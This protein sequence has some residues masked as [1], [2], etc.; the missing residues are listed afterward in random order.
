MMDVEPEPKRRYHTAYQSSAEFDRSLLRTIQEASPDG[1]LVVDGD[2]VIVSYNQ[3]FIETWQI[4]TDY[5]DANLDEN[6][7]IPEEKLMNAALAQLKDPEAFVRRV[8]ELYERPHEED[9]TEL[10]LRNGTVLERHSMGLHADD[11]HYF[12]RVWFFR[13]ITERKQGEKVL[14]DMAWYDPLTKELNRGHF[15][16]RAN[17]EIERAQRSHTPIGLLMLDLDHFKEVNDQYGHA[18]GDKVLEVACKRWRAALRSIDLLGR[19]GGEEFAIL[20]PDSDWK[21]TQSVA[22]RLR[23]VVADQPVCSGGVEIECTLSGGVVLVRPEEQNI[24]DA[25]SRADGALYRAK[26]NGRNR[27]EP[28]RPQEEHRE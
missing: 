13:D 19:L 20:L 1:I 7:T 14:R 11:G 26:A 21:T 4:P 28:E 25:L 18:A 15:L 23:S 2:G 5:L 8:Q 17:E 12:G 27:M 3:R 10:E 22:E 9:H 16:E 24:H 6:G